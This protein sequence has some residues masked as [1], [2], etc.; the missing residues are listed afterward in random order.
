MHACML[1][2]GDDMLDIRISQTYRI[3]L[4]TVERIQVMK[5][6]TGTSINELVNNFLKLGI[7]TFQEIEI[8][9]HIEKETPKKE[10]FTLGD[11]SRVEMGTPEGGSL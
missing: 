9:E 2:Q 5:A 11:L 6:K 10:K 3:D 1:A 7:E 8:D 4:E